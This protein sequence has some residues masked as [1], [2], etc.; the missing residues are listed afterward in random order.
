MHRDTQF[1]DSFHESYL[2]RVGVLNIIF[3]SIIMYFV[4]PC[5]QIKPI[6]FLEI[7]W[8]HVILLDK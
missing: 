5:C 3:I 4:P 2:V 6:N 1:P 7:H 8:K